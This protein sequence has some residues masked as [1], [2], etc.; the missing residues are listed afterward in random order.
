MRADICY[1]CLLGYSR[2][3]SRT[4]AGKKKVRERSWLE[5]HFIFTRQLGLAQS[6]SQTKRTVPERLGPLDQNSQSRPSYLIIY[7]F[8]PVQSLLVARFRSSR[9]VERIQRERDLR[10]Y[11]LVAQR[12]LTV[13]SHPGLL[14][15]R[16]FSNGGSA[17]DGRGAV[18]TPAKPS[19]QRRPS[20]SAA[21]REIHP[22]ALQQTKRC[23]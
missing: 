13:S 11:G 15:D 8:S 23:L 10:A 5:S 18:H 22:A 6:L 2:R 1:V 16:S 4:K 17:P 20:C 14:C 9:Y 21:P 12:K 19:P 3:A 7:A